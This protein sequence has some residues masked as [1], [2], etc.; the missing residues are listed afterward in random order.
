MGSLTE[1]EKQSEVFAQPSRPTKRVLVS[2]NRKGE[3]IETV[4]SKQAKN[5]KK[6]HGHLANVSKEQRK[7]NEKK[8]KESQERS[9]REKGKTPAQVKEMRAK[10]AEEKSKK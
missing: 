7:A 10:E 1:K 5:S 6:L 9:A 4:A 8:Y 3:E 2:D